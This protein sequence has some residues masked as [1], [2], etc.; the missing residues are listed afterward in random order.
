MTRN[1][2]D[3]ISICHCNGNSA[4]GELLRIA[5]QE[6]VLAGKAELLS[7]NKQ[8]NATTQ[9]NQAGLPKIIIVDGC[10]ER[11]LYKRHLDNGTLG[12]YYLNLEDVGIVPIHL[13]DIAREDIELA[14]D[15]IDA[16]CTDK[17]TR[18]PVLLA[19]CCCK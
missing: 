9:D 13:E 17:T 14:K 11:C 18:P 3:K 5:V 19:G 16:E 15:A 6:L 10:G 7:E 8:R 4:A 12:K 1:N 2:Q